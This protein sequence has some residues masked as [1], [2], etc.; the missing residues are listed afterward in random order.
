MSSPQALPIT[1]ACRGQTLTRHVAENASA[2]LCIVQGLQGQISAGSWW[3]WG[4]PR[5]HQVLTQIL[6]HIVP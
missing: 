3:P 1:L 2:Q 5:A 6:T 4:T